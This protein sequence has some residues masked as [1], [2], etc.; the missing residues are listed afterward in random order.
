MGISLDARYTYEWD[1]DEKVLTVCENESKKQIEDFWTEGVHSLAAIVGNNGAGKTS[2]L[3]AMLYVWGNEEVAADER[4][5]IVIYERDEKLYAYKPKG[6]E[7]TIKGVE[8]DCDEDT[9]ELEF[10]E[11]IFYFSSYFRPYRSLTTEGDGQLKGVYNA[12]DTWKIVYDLL[13]YS[14]VDTLNGPQL[15]SMHL[16]ALMSQ[17]NN[18]I[19]QM[20]V[21]KDMQ[22][23]LPKNI[24]PRYIVINPNYAGYYNLKDKAQRYDPYR[25][26][27][28]KMPSIHDYDDG[29]LFRFISTYFFNCATAIGKDPQHVLQIHQDWM[30]NLGQHDKAL[31]TLDRLRARHHYMED[32]LTL[33]WNAIEFLQRECELDRESMTL[34]IDTHIEDSERKV[35]ELMK[36]FSSNQRFLVEH[37]YDIGFART[38]DM[39]SQLSS[40]ETDMLKFFSRLYDAICLRPRKL[41][42]EQA[43]QML[44]IDEAENSYHPEWQR[45]FVSRLLK[46]LNALYLK[47]K[48]TKWEKD[49]QVVLTTHSPILLSDIPKMCINYLEKDSTTGKVRLSMEQAET[50]GANV[51]DLYR[52]TFFLQEG[53]VGVF[54]GEKIEQLYEEI[55]SGDNSYKK[56]HKR[57]EMIGDERIREYL[58]SMLVKDDKEVLIEYYE[59]KINELKGK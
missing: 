47:N 21:D 22:A 38:H 35:Q 1:K 32:D 42:S 18:R 51:F 56:Q 41:D 34:Y 12:T 52:K 28:I 23:L 16:N 14:N 7:C 45:Q 31:D 46:I 33:I 30:T 11:E 26:M 13:T 24:L 2:F 37:T 10:E 59:N 44:L 4:Q 53:M 39:K 43:P 20:L 50:F 58:L 55:K 17:D 9:E 5:A 40:G 49:F 54:A 48:G 36:H 27:A 3:E 19:A 25:K 8:S 29:L 15:L 6:C 57:V